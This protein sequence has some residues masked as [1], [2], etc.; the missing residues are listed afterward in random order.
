M[1]AFRQ[2]SVS[3]DHA[4]M[5]VGTDGV[6]LGSWAKGGI[7]ILDIGT[8][9]GII[10]LMMAQRFPMAAVAGIDID[11]E[12]CLQAK[13]NVAASPFAGR[14]M[15][16]TASLQEY[17]A[18]CKEGN[19][20]AIV[21]NPPYFRNSLKSPDG[22]RNMARHADTLSIRDLMRYSRKLLSANGALSVVGPASLRDDFDDE[23][24]FNGLR[25]VRRAMIK[26]TARKQPKRFLAE[27]S[28]DYFSP[29]EESVV[30]LLGSEGGPSEWYK[31]L[32]VDF[33]NPTSGR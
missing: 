19:F 23:A 28:P 17:A 3:D 33:M 27:Y 13:E 8:G 15:I 5:K 4:A 26:T 18:E 10:A 6:L 9:S 25:L 7:K 32:T 12:A 16:R 2:F 20:D 22:Q 11:H 1:F 24:G 31:E 21:C 14:M 29:P 30:C